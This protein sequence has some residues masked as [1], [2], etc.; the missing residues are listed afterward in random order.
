MDAP[1][2][3]VFETSNGFNRQGNAVLGCIAKVQHLMREAKFFEMS[4]QL[5]SHHH[6]RVTSRDARGGATA[7]CLKAH[8]GGVD[9]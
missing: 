9:V 1:I 4:S 7:E 5:G 3:A 6:Q 2:F 8:F